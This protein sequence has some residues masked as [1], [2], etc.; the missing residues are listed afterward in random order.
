MK[1][2]WLPGLEPRGPESTLTAIRQNNA[3]QERIFSEINNLFLF[4]WKK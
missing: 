4:I 1:I 3:G 2:G